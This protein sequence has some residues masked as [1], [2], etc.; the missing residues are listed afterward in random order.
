MFKYTFIIPYFNRPSLWNTLFTFKYFYSDR[1]DYQIFILEDKKNIGL[2]E[3]KL[4]EII[5]DYLSLPI[6]RF[7]MGH[8]NYSC[9]CSTYNEGVARASSEYVIITNPECAHVTNVLEGFD[10]SCVV[11]NCIVCACM[12]AKWPEKIPAINATLYPLTLETV[13]YQHSIYNN[14]CLC[15]GIVMAKQKYILSRGFNEY[16]DQGCGRA[17]VDF[18]KRS[19]KIV[20]YIP[21]DDLLLVHQW[22]PIGYPGKDY[23]SINGS[24]KDFKSRFNG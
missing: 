13:W 17:D 24:V 3:Q 5:S 16:F 23:R 18:L 14:R 4:T 2:A 9:P 12:C 8:D 20:K 1:D 11:D 7:K 22:H 21:K 6:V 19:S 10:K 15:F